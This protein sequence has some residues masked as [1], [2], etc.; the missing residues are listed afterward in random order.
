MTI[1]ML[2]PPIGKIDT[3]Y[4]PSCTQLFERIRQTSTY[5]PSTMWPPLC[6]ECRQPVAARGL[7]ADGPDMIF[8]CLDHENERW[9]WS[10]TAAQWRRL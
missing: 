10:R 5:Y 1:E 3:G 9:T 7:D 8:S 4:C 2:E 6:R